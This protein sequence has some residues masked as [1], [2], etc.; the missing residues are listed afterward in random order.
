MAILGTVTR[1]RVLTLVTCRW[2]QL[3]RRIEDMGE[4]ET[5]GNS[6]TSMQAVALRGVVFY[7]TLRVFA[8]V[9]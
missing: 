4:R 9:L 1:R 6:T 7:S 3:S 5:G 8:A 2:G